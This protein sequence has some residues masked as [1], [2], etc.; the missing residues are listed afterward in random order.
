MNTH[1]VSVN[2]MTASTGDFL[3][4]IDPE[5]G[6]R[7]DPA[8]HLQ[9]RF[10]LRGLMRSKFFK[11]RWYVACGPGR[12]KQITLDLGASLRPEY[13]KLLLGLDTFCGCCHAK[14]AAEARDCTN[15]CDTVV[16]LAE[17]RNE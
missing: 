17:F 11:Q 16:F 6:D 2:S 1:G 4:S 13:F 14:T 9:S 5:N 3:N 10:A 15:D 7:V 8:R 12:A